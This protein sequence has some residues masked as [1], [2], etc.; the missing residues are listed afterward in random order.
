M[1][2]FLFFFFSSENSR[3][4]KNQ[5]RKIL[6]FWKIRIR[7][8]SFCG[9]RDSENSR[10]VEKENYEICGIGEFSFLR[11]MRIRELT[12]RGKQQSKNSRFVENENPRIPV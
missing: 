4:V 5:N 7:E 8:F 2:Q 12:F 9:K 1:G 10:F 3:F 6:F 11:K